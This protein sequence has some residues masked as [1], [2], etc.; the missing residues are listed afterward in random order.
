MHDLC[1]F[2]F[3]VQK[4][5]LTKNYFLTAE[6]NLTTRGPLYTCL[7]FQRKLHFIAAESFSGGLETDSCWTNLVEFDFLKGLLL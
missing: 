5:I 6:I 7:L 4:P 1:I 3:F 2:D